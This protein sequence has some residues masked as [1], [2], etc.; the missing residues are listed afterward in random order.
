[1]HERKYKKLNFAKGAFHILHFTRHIIKFKE[2]RTA[3][4][5]VQINGIYFGKFSCNET[6]FSGCI[7]C[8]TIETGPLGYSNSRYDALFEFAI[9]LSFMNV[10]SG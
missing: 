8:E 10:V 9:R 1:M 6:S 2:L 3:L 4:D 5:F 7:Q